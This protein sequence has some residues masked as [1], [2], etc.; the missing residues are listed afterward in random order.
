MQNQKLENQLNLALSVTE[1]VRQRTLDLDIGFFDDIEVWELIVKYNGNILALEEELGIE[2]EI[3]TNEYAILYVPEFLINRLT[4]YPQIEFIEKPKL[5][6]YNMDL[7]KRAACI[8]RVQEPPY[9]LTGEGVIVAIIDSGIDY[10]HQDFRNEDGS[11]RIIELWD[12]SIPGDPPEG[13]VQGTVYTREQIN[14]ALAERTRTDQLAIVPSVDISGHGTHVAGIAAG[15]GRASAGRYTGVAPRSD[16]L[17][18]KIGEPATESYP[19]T[20]ELMRAITYVINKAQELNQPVAINLSFGN[21]YG[22]RDGSSLLETFIDTMAG[23]GR[24]VIVIGSGN[25]GAAGHHT[26]GV[27][28]AGTPVTVEI[29]VASTERTLNIQ[30]W[31][32]YY[33]TIDI[34]IINPAGI[35]VGPLTRRLGTQ[36]FIMGRTEVFVYYGEPTP[37]NMAQEIYIEL[38]PLN[39]YIDGGIWRIRLSPINIIVGNYNLW[40]PSSEVIQTTTRFLSP[41]VLTTLTT[42]GSAHRAITVGAY[43]SVTNSVAD[44]SGRGFTRYYDFVKPELVAPGVNITAAAPGGGYDTKSGTSMAT[45]FVTGASALLMEWGIVRGND[46]FL[47]GEKIKAYLIDG[48]SKPIAR[49]AYPNTELGFGALCLQSSLD[50]ALFITEIGSM[51]DSEN[52]MDI[53]LLLPVFINFS[54]ELIGNIWERL[55]EKIKELESKETVIVGFYGEKDE[56]DFKELP[57]KIYNLRK[58]KEN[59]AVNILVAEIRKWLIELIQEIDTSKDTAYYLDI[60]KLVIHPLDLISLFSYLNKK[61]KD[62]NSYLLLKKEAIFDNYK[63]IFGPKDKNKKFEFEV[64]KSQDIF[65]LCIYGAALDNYIIELISPEKEKISLKE[66]NKWKEDKNY[67]D[68]TGTTIMAKQ[69]QSSKM[70]PFLIKLD[71]MKLREG[72][73]EINIIG[74]VII[75]GRLTIIPNGKKEEVTFKGVTLTIGENLEENIKIL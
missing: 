73:W 30:I 24:N 8:A 16:L 39:A 60:D 66:L 21:N 43:N 42:P 51:D 68:I 20:T 70:D 59:D 5:L 41:T 11:T 56:K 69:Y 26:G 61:L 52:Y 53:N 27:L 7:S 23:V 48:T 63:L 32:S 44:F 62:K 12:Q 2:V 40:L 67:L 58:R 1:R 38:V 37:Y 45:P 29:A 34:Y 3:L 47:Y 75:D 4:A 50:R 6:F 65:N 49:F 28:T 31:K 36:R 25:E 54:N 14:E 33:D 17:I 18:V 55:V 74:N 15:N 57:C 9:N 22:P 46:P 19:R 71:F 35:E 64:K 10:A 72:K 13:F